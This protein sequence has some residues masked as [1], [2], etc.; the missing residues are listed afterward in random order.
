MAQGVKD[1]TAVAQVTAEEGVQSLAWPSGLKDPVLPKLWCRSQ[2]WLEFSPGLGTS[3]F[4]MYVY[5]MCV[6]T[7]IH[8]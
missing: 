1:L 3:I 6:Y 5:K 7:H 4:S 8:T 2:L